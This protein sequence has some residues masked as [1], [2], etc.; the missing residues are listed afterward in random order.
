MAGFLG[1]PSMDSLHCPGP[2]NPK[3]GV[4]QTPPT[5]H[6]RRA[7]GS[8]SALDGPHRLGK[9]SSAGRSTAPLPADSLQQNNTTTPYIQIYVVGPTRRI[10]ALKFF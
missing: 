5:H 2:K 7:F 10:P 8:P 9:T 3:V 6:V 4:T 1:D